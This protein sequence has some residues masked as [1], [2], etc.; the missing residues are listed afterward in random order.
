MHEYSAS[1]ISWISTVQLFLMCV[2]HYS[3]KKRRILI[4]ACRFGFCGI[5]G[6]VIDTYGVKFIIF[7]SAILSTLSIALLSLCR[8]YAEV[9][10][11]QGV[12]FGIGA[13][14]MFACAM[15]ACGQW[16]TKY[17]ALAMGVVASG[18]SMGMIDLSSRFQSSVSFHWSDVDGTY[19]WRNPSNIH[20]NIDA[21][22]GI[23]G[24]CSICSV[25]DWRLHSH[26]MLHRRNSTTARKMGQKQ[27]FLQRSPI[28]GSCLHYLHCGIVLR[29]VGPLILCSF[30]PC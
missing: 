17:R 28:Q 12:G 23:P 24:C 27:Q 26:I 25:S 10:L 3:A 2:N 21:G 11:A 18:S 6:S 29:Y 13:S 9:F 22:T 20:P 19:R 8:T 4:G 7:P 16:F 14:G 1:A 15:V 5:Y 30:W